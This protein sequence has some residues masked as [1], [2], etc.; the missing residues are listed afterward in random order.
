MDNSLDKIV[1]QKIEYELAFKNGYN[2]AIYSDEPEL[3]EDPKIDYRS[4]S[5]IGYY[6]GF[7][8]AEYCIRIG[9]QFEVKPE[10]FIAEVDKRFTSAIKRQEDFRKSSEIVDKMFTIS[11]GIK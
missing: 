9:N 1:L 7:K 3:L 5:S 10:N 4:F 11:G 2:A 8:Y 6:D